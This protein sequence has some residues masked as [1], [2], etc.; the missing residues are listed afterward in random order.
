MVGGH[1]RRHAT[2]T[3]SRF[4]LVERLAGS[5][6]EPNKT[7]VRGEREYVQKRAIVNS[8]AGRKSAS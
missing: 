5:A 6:A 7:F 2:P 8:A 4:C 1:S 3:V